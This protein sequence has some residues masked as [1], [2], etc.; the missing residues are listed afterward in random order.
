MAPPRQEE[1][2]ERKIQDVQS[3]ELAEYWGNVLHTWTF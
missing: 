3:G 1:K 2:K